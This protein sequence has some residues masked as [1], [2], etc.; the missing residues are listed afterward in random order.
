MNLVNVNNSHVN[1]IHGNKQDHTRQAS[2]PNPFYPEGP[3]QFDVDDVLDLIQIVIVN[4]DNGMQI[5][6][7]N[8]SID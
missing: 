7:W 8:L 1:I 4:V 5:C 2:G 3:I 6:A